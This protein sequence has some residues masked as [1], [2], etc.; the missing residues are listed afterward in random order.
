MSS[1]PKATV[2]NAK[3]CSFD[4]PGLNTAADRASTFAVFT[5]DV[6][7]HEFELKEEEGYPPLRETEHAPVLEAVFAE[8]YHKHEVDP[9][10]GYLLIVRIDPAHEEKMKRD[11]RVNFEFDF[12]YATDD[13]DKL[14]KKTQKFTFDFDPD[15]TLNDGLC[16]LQFLFTCG[17]APRIG[18]LDFKEIQLF[19]LSDDSALGFPDAVAIWPGTDKPPDAVTLQVIEMTP[20]MEVTDYLDTDLAYFEDEEEYPPDE[21]DPS[22]LEATDEVTAEEPE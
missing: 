20:E 10:P 14:E 3:K 8:M 2:L 6:F 12:H 1:E 15:K 22:M 19:D 5:G 11:P 16:Y 4:K 9:P 7:A 18:E 21:D 13:P 17:N